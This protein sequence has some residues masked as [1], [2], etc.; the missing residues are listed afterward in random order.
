MRKLTT[1]SKSGLFLMELILSLLFLSLASSVCIRLFADA[2][3]CQKKARELNHIRE[4]TTSVGEILEGSRPEPEAFAA[5]LPGGTISGNLV[6]YSY[7]AAW[8]PCRAED[9][10]YQME[11]L[12]SEAAS[13]KKAVLTFR[14]RSGE[15][16]FTQT[17]RY[18]RFTGQKEAGQ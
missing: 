1:H 7:D 9:A 14:N 13:E 16:L 15:T 17:I 2:R 12:L 10:A 5:L 18:P 6:E 3:V 8:K 4:L 11:L